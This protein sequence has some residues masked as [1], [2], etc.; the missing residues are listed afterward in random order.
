[1]IVCIHY[2]MRRSSFGSQHDSGAE[3]MGDVGVTVNCFMCWSG[4]IDGQTVRHKLDFLMMWY[5]QITIA[6]VIFN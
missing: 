5:V 4:S 6:L 3:K 2:I 1:M